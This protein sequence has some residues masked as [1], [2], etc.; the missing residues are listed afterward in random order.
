MVYIQNQE[1]N[2][3]EIIIEPINLPFEIKSE[4]FLE[5]SNK[6]IESGNLRG[7]VNTVTNLKRAIDCQL[8]SM[9]LCYGLYKTSDE[10]SWKF[11]KKIQ[12]L[13]SIG[14]KIPGK[15]HK[16]NDSRVELE[17]RYK[18]PSKSELQEFF[19]ISKNF[20]QSTK[21]HAKS[22]IKKMVGK[23]KDGKAAEIDFNRQREEIEIYIENRLFGSKITPINPDY[24]RILKTVTQ[25]IEA[26]IN[27]S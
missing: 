18:K 10:Q 6:D 25:F 26:G 5:I 24:K 13:E 1:I 17:H 2:V 15:V 19:D 21:N 3:E 9:L 22:G 16:I 11:P 20:I 23:T 12:E 27:K 4:D 8:D 14:I 7:L